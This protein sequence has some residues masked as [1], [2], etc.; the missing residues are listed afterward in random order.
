MKPRRE[1]RRQLRDNSRTMTEESP[2]P[3]LVVITAACFEAVNR[4]QR[5]REFS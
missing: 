2:T 1:G 5:E 3:A 4:G